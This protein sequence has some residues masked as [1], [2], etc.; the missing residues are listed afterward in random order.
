MILSSAVA[1]CLL[2]LAEAATGREDWPLSGYPMY[3]KPQSKTANRVR[4]VGVTDSGEFLLTREHT[5][6]FSGSRLNSLMKRLRSHDRRRSAFLDKLRERYD[7]RREGRQ[8][9]LRGIRIYAESWRI[10]SGLAG[11]ESPR[12]VLEDSAYFA[13]KALLDRLTAEEEETAPEEASVPLPAGELVLE[14]GQG[15]CQHGCDERNEPYASEGRAL[16]LRPERDAPGSAV[17]RFEGPPGE[18]SLFLRMRSREKPGNDRVKLELD[19]REVDGAPDGLGHYREELPG[20][21]WVWASVAAGAPPLELELSG[22]SS[23][24]IRLSAESIV[25]LDQ[26]WLS[27][28]TRELPSE[29]RVRQR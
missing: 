7:S 29:N 2:T 5:A 16:R 13:P 20:V 21:G 17:L 6:P 8:R 18:Y 23:H 24:S 19:G 26:L 25:Y 15:A 1:F 10:R 9:P 28:R 12:R 14:L 22:A 11:I 27:R 4:L 3:S